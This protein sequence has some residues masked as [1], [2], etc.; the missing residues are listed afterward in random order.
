MTVQKIKQEIYSDREEFLSQLIKLQDDNKKSLTQTEDKKEEK[1]DDKKDDKKVSKEYKDHGFEDLD[2]HEMTKDIMGGDHIS[3]KK[4]H[5]KDLDE[6][7][8]ID[9]KKYKKKSKYKTVE[10]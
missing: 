6:L 5:A 3:G 8:E 7:D 2:E 9:E 4:V 10:G 1:K